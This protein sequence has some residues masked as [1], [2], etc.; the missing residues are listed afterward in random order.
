MLESMTGVSK[1]TFKTGKFEFAIYMRSINHRFRDF[2]IKY[3][4]Q[5]AFM[6]ERFM[7]IMNAKI[8][9]GRVDA[10]I[11]ING[12]LEGPQVN[13]RVINEYLEICSNITGRGV[14]PDES[15]VI[16]LLSLPGA[17][18]S[19]E[20]SPDLP[21]DKI[22]SNFEKAVNQLQKSRGKMLII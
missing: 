18:S 12:P 17:V 21:V 20:S 19:R 4:S 6:H 9:R 7:N 3:P 8:K 5:L 13:K 15:M 22:E 10:E 11:I 2:Y 14:K 1:S 16:N